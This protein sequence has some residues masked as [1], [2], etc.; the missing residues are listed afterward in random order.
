M[1]KQARAPL[2]RKGGNT[3]SGEMNRPSLNPL[4]ALWEKGSPSTYHYRKAQVHFDT[5]RQRCTLGEGVDQKPPTHNP[6]LW[7]TDQPSCS[8]VK[9]PERLSHQP[10]LWPGWV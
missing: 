9:N 6:S 5:L 10:G 2:A 8:G 7:G 3:F 4:L 1:I